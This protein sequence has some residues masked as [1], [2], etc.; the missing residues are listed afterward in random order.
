MLFSAVEGVYVALCSCTQTVP[1]YAHAFTY[2]GIHLAMGIYIQPNMH[3]YI[4]TCIH[5][6][7]NQVQ[8]AVSLPSRQRYIQTNTYIHTYTHTYIH[9]YVYTY[10]L[11]VQVA[12]SLPSATETIKFSHQM[13][14][15]VIK[16]IP[17]SMKNAAI[18][19]CRATI[20]ELMGQQVTDMALVS[21][22]E[23]LTQA[24]GSMCVYM[25]IYMYELY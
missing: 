2:T 5:A 23:H 14:N 13:R 22:R 3:T 16:D 10:I 7:I 17:L 11:Q 24:L 25:Y 20:M 12:V 15:T 6:Y 18:D 4:H 9:I 19:K 8:V 21:A 1:V